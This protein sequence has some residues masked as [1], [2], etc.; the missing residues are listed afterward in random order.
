MFLE[1][2]GLR[3]SAAVPMVVAAMLAVSCAEASVPD[4]PLPP[5]EV[6]KVRV[7]VSGAR[8]PQSAS[9]VRLYEA[10][11]L[12]GIQMLRFDASLADARSFARSA[13]GRDAV[14]GEDPQNL[15]VG[16]EQEWWLDSFPEGAEG[17]AKR[18]NAGSVEIVLLP[19]GE[20]ATIWMMARLR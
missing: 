19:R 10:R 16:A 4:A 11:F 2:K 5:D 17:G 12:D 20:R 8:L 3:R 13:L 7:A 9:D 18:D 1:S 14:P 15:Y 6:A